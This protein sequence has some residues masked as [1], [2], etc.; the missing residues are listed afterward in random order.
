M[1]LGLNLGYM[2][3]AD[4]ARGQLRL[5]QH[6][7]SLG[8]DSTFVTHIAGRDSLDQFLIEN[9]PRSSPVAIRGR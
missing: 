1:R 9:P 8:Y 4:D 7:E 5:T 3:G 6:A 2:V